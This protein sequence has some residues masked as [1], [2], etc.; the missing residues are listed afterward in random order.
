MRA[1]YRLGE[2]C[3][4]TCKVWGDIR[5]RYASGLLGHLIKKI[6]LE[7]LTPFLTPEIIL[8]YVN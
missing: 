5:R 7:F 2:K 4:V 8:N 6:T 3:W 1:E